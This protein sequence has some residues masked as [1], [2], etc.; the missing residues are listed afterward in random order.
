MVAGDLVIGIFDGPPL[1]DGLARIGIV[2]EKNHHQEV[3]PPVVKVLW[4]DGS[5]DKQW[6][7][8]LE[9]FSESR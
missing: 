5:I 8:E 6:T 7:D 9:V 3:V 4:Q 2:I 1:G